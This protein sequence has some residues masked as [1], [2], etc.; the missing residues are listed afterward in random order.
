MYECCVPLNAAN[1]PRY[2]VVMGMIAR[3]GEGY[4][5]PSYH[6]LKTSLLE[7]IKKECK[8]AIEN[9]RSHWKLTGC[10]I[11]ADGWTD[12]RHR[13]L[14]NFLVYCPAG[15]CF[16][17]SIDASGII[18]TAENLFSL[19]SEVIEWVGPK[20]VVHVVTDNA[21]NYVSA[22]KMITQKY[23]SI[24]WDPCVAHTMNLIM[25]D[26][27][28][29]PHVSSLAKRASKVTVFVY[30]HGSILHWLKQRSTWKEIVRPAATRFATTFFTLSSILERQG[31]LQALVISEFFRD[32]SFYKTDVGKEVKSIILD[33]KFWDDC[34]FIVQLTIPIVKLLRIVDSDSKPALGYVHEGMRRVEDGVKTVCGN[35]EAEYK[36]YIDIIEARWDKHL[37]RDLILAAYFF[38]PALRYS[39]GFDNSRHVSNAL[40][41]IFE[42]RA[43]CS[44]SD[45]DKAID[46][47]G[48][49][50][51][52]EGVFGRSLAQQGSQHQQPSA[53]WEWFGKETLIIQKLAIR[54]VSQTVASYGCERNWSV[55]DRIHTK[56][57]NMLEHKRLSD[58]V[59]V[60]YNMRLQHR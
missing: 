59:F 30:N 9:L 56:K 33:Q 52:G 31:D 27:C 2:S 41:N 19:F 47:M 43:I 35:V 12:K 29:L 6:A 42:N 3:M 58:L 25:K 57:R 24:Y 26:I 22:G 49:Y 11:M 38:N 5:G 16:V 55:F 18:K 20:N 32:S 14:I 40:F 50:E 36:P 45:S 60:H 44:L 28:N 4:T 54:I 46:E 39:A 51:K 34:M 1:S 53:W 37:N 23:K 17:R 8:L 48:L 13:S 7:D 15:T 10:T 21:A